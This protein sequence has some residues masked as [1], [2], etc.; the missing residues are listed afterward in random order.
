[1]GS[2]PAMFFIFLFLIYTFVWSSVNTS[3]YRAPIEPEKEDTDDEDNR[4]RPMGY[5]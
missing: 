2:N 4:L 3:Y 1:M 5:L